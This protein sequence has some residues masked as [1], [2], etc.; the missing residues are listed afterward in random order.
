M[1]PPLVSGISSRWFQVIIDCSWMLLANTASLKVLK[2]PLKMLKTCISWTSPNSVRK[3][4]EFFCCI[5]CE[6]HNFSWNIVFQ[7][8]GETD[9][10]ACDAES[11]QLWWTYFSKR[12]HLLEPLCKYME[13][14]HKTFPTKKEL[15]VLGS[16]T[17]YQIKCDGV[18]VKG[19]E[20]LEFQWILFVGQS[21]EHLHSWDWEEKNKTEWFHIACKCHYLTH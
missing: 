8:E 15:F 11:R 19:S 4:A 6:L 9:K 10:L 13:M 3:V 1:T 5:L 7:V 14:K 21:A 18:P 17:V 20:R 12:I 2:K 16:S